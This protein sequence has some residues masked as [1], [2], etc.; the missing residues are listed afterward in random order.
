MRNRQKARFSLPLA[1]PCS[2]AR[3][4]YSDTE[5]SG[6]AQIPAVKSGENFAWKFPDKLAMIWYRLGPIPKAYFYLLGL[7]KTAK[8]PVLTRP[9]EE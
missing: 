1:P 3:Y 8:S 9:G 6:I 4:P 5:K 7:L 2:K